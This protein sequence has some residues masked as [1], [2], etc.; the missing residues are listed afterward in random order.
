HD[1]PVTRLT[2]S[3][4]TF[5]RPVPSMW[6]STTAHRPICQH[7]QMVIQ[8][9]EEKGITYPIHARGEKGLYD[10]VSHYHFPVHFP[11]GGSPQT[12]TDMALS[13]SAEYRISV[14]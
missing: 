7:N 10:D 14:V 11:I 12:R 1:I 3:D 5:A 8:Q 6:H 4:S 13:R 2:R 9:T